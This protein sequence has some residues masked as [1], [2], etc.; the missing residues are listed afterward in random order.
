MD[1]FSE[2]MSANIRIVLI[3]VVAL[4][5]IA[6]VMGM[7]SSVEGDTGDSL[8]NSTSQSDSQTNKGQCVAQC[9]M[10][11]PGGGAQFEDCRSKC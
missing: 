3:I 7:W 1:R 5:A 10:N 6:V 11:Y 2:G 4:I 8:D 9:R